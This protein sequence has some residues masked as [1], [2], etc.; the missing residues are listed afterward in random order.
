MFR[1]F[2]RS[3][4]KF[5]IAIQTL[6]AISKIIA[7]THT[8]THSYTHSNIMMAINMFMP[9]QTSKNVTHYAARKMRSRHC[10]RFTSQYTTHDAPRM[11]LNHHK[12]RPHNK[13]PP[14]RSMPFSSKHAPQKA[15]DQTMNAKLFM[16]IC[17]RLNRNS[18]AG[19]WINLMFLFAIIT[20]DKGTRSH[21]AHSMTK[22]NN[23]T[24][25][26]SHPEAKGF[27]TTTGTVRF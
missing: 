17:N 27:R 14:K 7:H 16:P 9:R 20:H 22:G 8:H 1:R 12:L 25:G 23:A 10:P 15:C 24:R 3:R 19:T 2:F 5:I 18:S 4:C 21:S 13:A 26:K 6:I 11:L